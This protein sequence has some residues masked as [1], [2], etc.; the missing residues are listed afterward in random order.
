MVP[1]RIIER[2][3]WAPGLWSFR[4]DATI[5]NFVPGRFLN[6]GLEVDGELVKRSYSLGSPPGAPPEFYL[7]RVEGGALTPPLYEL[8]VGDDVL[9]SPRAAGFFT[10]DEV[11]NARDLWMVATGTGIAPYVSMLRAGEGLD[12]FER[13]VV[14]HGVRHLA[15]LGYRTELE[16]MAAEGKLTYLPACTRESAEGVLDGRLPERLTD[17]G[18]EARAGVEVT[19]AHSHVMLCGNPGMIDG[20]VATLKTRDMSK[21]RRRRP[22]HISFEKYW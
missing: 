22:G 8:G 13:I 4:V 17:G 20:I 21:H 1:S 15:D 2:S 19:P 14:V 9:V 7:V 12:R 16:T 3:D 5:D 6:V 10:L 18:L 11:P